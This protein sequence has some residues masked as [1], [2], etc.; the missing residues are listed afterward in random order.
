MKFG[1]LKTQMQLAQNNNLK[2]EK[3]QLSRV[4]EDFHGVTYS[5]K[6]ASTL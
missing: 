6:F 5:Y 4:L 2:P 1:E 3:N